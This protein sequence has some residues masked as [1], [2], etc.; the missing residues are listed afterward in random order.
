MER[1]LNPPE[2]YLDEIIEEH[3]CEGCGHE[4]PSSSAEASYKWTGDVWCDTCMV[5]N[6]ETCG[7]WDEPSIAAAERLGAPHPD[8]PTE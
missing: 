2:Y 4:V 6:A 1:E 8:T 5:A 3:I 7:D